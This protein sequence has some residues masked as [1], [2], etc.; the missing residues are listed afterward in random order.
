MVPDILR[1]V[2]MIHSDDLVEVW[3]GLET[4]AVACGFHARY[5]LPEV[6]EAHREVMPH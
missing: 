3:H 2:R 5:Y 6:F 4:P 1:G